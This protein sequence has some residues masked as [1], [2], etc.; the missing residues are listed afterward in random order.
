MERSGGDGVDGTGAADDNATTTAKKVLCA[1]ANNN[2]VLVV[3][4]TAAARSLTALAEE[5]GEDCPP[6]GLGNDPAAAAVN[7][8]RQHQSLMEAI[9]AQKM[10]QEGRRHRRDKWR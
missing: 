2:N 5:E 1:E 9:L 4:G 7:K 3:S 6:A 10:A 8:E